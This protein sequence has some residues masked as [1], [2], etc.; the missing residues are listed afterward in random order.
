MLNDP[1]Q[2]IILIMGIATQVGVTGISKKSRLLGFVVG[3]ASQPLWFYTAY[4][5]GQWGV[6]AM[7]I[8]YSAAYAR[9][10][11]NSKQN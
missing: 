3:L 9:G 5:H 1:A 6:F 4:T 7:A 8:V 2:V 11:W 10:I